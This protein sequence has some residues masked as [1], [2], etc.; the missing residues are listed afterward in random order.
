MQAAFKAAKLEFRIQERIA[1]HSL[2][3]AYTTQLM[4]LG[5]DLRLVQGSLGHESINAKAR[6]AHIIKVLREQNTDRTKS[7]LAGFE[8]RC[9]DEPS[10]FS[11][12]SLKISAMSWNVCMDPTCFPAI[13]RPCLPWHVAGGRAAI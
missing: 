4:E 3:H 6:Y 11:P 1:V 8:L 12:L 9:E 10:R 5:M 13:A 7:L 2:R